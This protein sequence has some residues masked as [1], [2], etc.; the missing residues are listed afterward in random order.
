[1]RRRTPRRSPRARPGQAA[2]A[3]RAQARPDPPPAQRTR[4]GS[5]VGGRRPG[6]PPGG[7]SY[8][9][10]LPAR[11]PGAPRTGR[12]P[13]RRSPCRPS[14]PR[15]AAR[16]ARTPAAAH[17]SPGSS[18]TAAAARTPSGTGQP[19]GHGAGTGTRPPAAPRTTGTPGAGPPPAGPPPHRRRPAA[20]TAIPWPRATPPRIP[21]RDVTKRRREGILHI[22]KGTPRSWP[23][24]AG[25]GSNINKE[26]GQAPHRG[27]QVIRPST[28]GAGVP[29]VVLL[30]PPRAHPP[31]HFPGCQVSAGG[32]GMD[33][34]GPAAAGRDTAGHLPQADLLALARPVGDVQRHRGV[35]EV[36]LV[37]P[38]SVIGAGDGR[39][40]G[41]GHVVRRAFAVGEQVEP[42][43]EDVGEQR[44][45]PAAPAEAHR[46][47]PAVSA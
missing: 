16:P 39:E 26:H 31:A 14:P 40:R 33:L 29:E 6:P 25:P 24:P 38:A 35:G 18:R 27:A 41:G 43:P 8:T 45:G 15:P 10:R 28:P 42:G 1:M 3:G 13:P 12:P 37:R 19:P 23:A 46:H 30:P 7:R 22:P 34:A 36:K 5:A 44:R 9:A 4:P 17:G 47:P 32:Q 11:R 21:S 20:G 2:P